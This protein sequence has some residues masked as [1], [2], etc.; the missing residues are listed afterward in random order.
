MIGKTVRAA[1][2]EVFRRFPMHGDRAKALGLV[3]HRLQ[4]VGTALL[5]GVADSRPQC[6][7]GQHQEKPV[8]T[9]FS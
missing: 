3:T 4:S 9:G 1:G 7:H 6:Q 5:G 2:L 8:A